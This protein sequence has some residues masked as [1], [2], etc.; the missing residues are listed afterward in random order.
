MLLGGTSLV[1]MWFSC[2]LLQAL[3]NHRR[4]VQTIEEHDVD[5]LT[6]IEDI[7]CQD[8]A[9]L[10]AFTIT[11]KFREN[12]YFTNSVLSKK[13]SVSSLLSSN[14]I[15]IEK[16]RALVLASCCHYCSRRVSILC[17]IDVPRYSY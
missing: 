12:P 3:E 16:V 2:L 14:N 7:T 5:A 17:C 13:L 11:F 9:D 8:D 10:T 1:L 15:S 6:Y 4:L